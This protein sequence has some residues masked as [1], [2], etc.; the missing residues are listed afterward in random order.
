[1]KF[2]WF[3]KI[4]ITVA[5]APIIAGS[6]IIATKLCNSALND[7]VI[8]KKDC[9]IV[10]ISGPINGHLEHF[11]YKNG[12]QEIKVN[13]DIL[14]FQKA[15]K[16]F[17]DFDGDNKTDF[18]KLYGENLF[19]TSNDLTSIISRENDSGKF[20]K[21]FNEGDNLFSMHPNNYFLAEY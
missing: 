1:V 10:S 3:S 20:E 14:E 16:V 9:G 8:E 5:M 13:P 18:V 12:Y 6:A 19:T 15:S 11:V 4:V 2:D 17:I 21:L 7:Y